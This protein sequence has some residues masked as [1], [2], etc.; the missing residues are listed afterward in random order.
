MKKGMA[1]AKG[2]CNTTLNLSKDADMKIAV[3]RKNIEAIYNP[4]LPKG[5]RANHHGYR[6]PVHQ[7]ESRLDQALRQYEDTHRA[8]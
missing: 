5:C 2:G 8:Q 4:A 1:A 7:W 6:A 3:E